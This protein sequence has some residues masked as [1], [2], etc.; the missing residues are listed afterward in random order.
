MSSE[1]QRPL[2]R[3]A[4]VADHAGGAADQGVRRVAGLLEPARG[5]DLH[6]GCPCAGSA[7][8]G[9][10]RR[11]TGRCPSASA[12]RRASRSV[13]CAISPRHSRS[14]S[15]VGSGAHGGQPAMRRAPAG[16]TS[17]RGH[18]GCLP[19]AT[20][21]HRDCVHS[22]PALRHGLSP[23]LAVLSAA[24]CCARAERRR[25]RSLLDRADGRARRRG[26]TQPA[27]RQ[28]GRDGARCWRAACTGSSCCRP[29]RS[30][31]ATGRPPS[32]SVKRFQRRHHVRVT[33]RV[34]QQRLEHD[35]RAR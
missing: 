24:R 10:S 28:P 32:N 11:R 12:S 5:E 14:S 8:S 7:P 27:P 13:E 29:R 34:N 3:V 18:G 6:A 23:L 31:A 4:R 16:A 17:A 19:N 30:T 1:L 25:W 22:R 9:R 2:A 35:R 20:L 15:R 21:E 26:G 33:G